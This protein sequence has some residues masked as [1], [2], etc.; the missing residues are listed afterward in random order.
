MSPTLR[1]DTADRRVVVI[2]AGHAGVQVAET[3]RAAG[4][5]GP[6]TL[7]GDE[8]TLPY[9]RPPLSK[10]HLGS[11]EPEPLPLRGAT[12]YREH[13]IELRTGVTA[14]A[15]CREKRTVEVS[16]GRTLSYDAL[17]LACGATNRT[18]PVAGADLAGIHS[19]RTLAEAGAVR[20]ALSDSR[21]AL[22][23]GAGFI[24]LEFAAAARK[25]DI[26]VTVLE[27]AARPLGRAVTKEMA[28][29]IAEVHRSNGVDLRLGEGV[30]EFVG[31]AGH[32]RGAI[33]SSGT[34]YE[35]D[36]VLVGVGVVPRVALAAQAG[37]LVDNG[38][39]VDEQMRTSDPA[40][41]A[42]GD[43]ASFP[44]SFTGSRVRLESVQ[45]AT[46]QARHV[47]GAILGRREQGTPAGYAE[48]PWFWSHQG[49]LKLQIAGLRLPGDRSYVLGDP[50]TGRFS[51]CCY[52]DGRLVAV[53]SLNRPADH[54]AARRLLA[55]RRSPAP[56]QLD[57]PDFTLKAFARTLAP[58]S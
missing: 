35:A 34:R 56:D 48:L 16:D 8:P 11:A 39:V 29:H 12:F 19:L 51:V 28:D 41:Y 30:R 3:L 57:D 20:E 58:A 55:D 9:Q 38:I 25:R 54:M 47:A 32:V 42:V 7:V 49:D 43:C 50:D 26:A 36:L 40:I 5:A 10:E 31:A 27:A 37:L 14:N 33:G 21:S 23:I 53:E 46:D 2:G 17:V 22:V 1:S 44:D 15:I 13:G 52:R 24:G 4:H 6:L 45:N 18:L